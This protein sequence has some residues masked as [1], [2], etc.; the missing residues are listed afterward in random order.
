MRVAP[1]I[2]HVEGSAEHIFG[3]VCGTFRIM[4]SP[5][6]VIISRMLM[7]PPAPGAGA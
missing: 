4:S 2:V 6:P 3:A 5:G 1:A 7:K